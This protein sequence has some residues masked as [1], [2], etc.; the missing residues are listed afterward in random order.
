MQLHYIQPE[1]LP[2]YAQALVHI[3][4]RF[5]LRVVIAFLKRIAALLSY[6]VYI[7]LPTEV[8]QHQN[9]SEQL[10]A[11]RIVR[12]L[13]KAGY[14]QHSRYTTT[15]QP[16]EPPAHILIHKLAEDYGIGWS[17]KAAHTSDKGY[18]Q[19]PALGE[20]VERYSLQHSHF[21]PADLVQSSN[22]NLT[23]PKVDIFAI[24]S[25]S[26]SE[27]QLS[28]AP[29]QLEYTENDVFTWVSVVEAQTGKKVYAPWQWFSFEHL[30]CEV[31]TKK[32]EPLLTPAITTGA[33]A[34]QT[35]EQA[36]LAGLLEVIERDAF[37][38][39]WLQ[40]LQANRMNLT[41]IDNDEVQQLVQLA[42]DYRLELHM[43]YLQTDVPVHTISLVI[44][45][46]SG[47]GPAVNIS[48][49]T[50]FAMIPMIIDVLQD[51]LAQ[52]GIQYDMLKAYPDMA[53]VP[54]SK[55]THVSRMM[56]W[57]N[58]EL[59]PDIEHFLAG[60]LSELTDLPTYQVENTAAARL[61]Y[62]Y[63]WFAEQ[64]YPIYYRE[65]I[66]PELK[67]LTEGVSVVMVKVPAMQP[68][69]LE[70]Q[71]KATGGTRLQS[72]PKVLGLATWHDAHGEYYQVPHPFP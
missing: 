46:R 59:I 19:W 48:A 71:L 22:K 20:A 47:I 12:K 24:A 36:T 15:Q 38:I 28:T 18:L 34:G 6:P 42:K 32:S 63:T 58:S 17:G 23:K 65:I 66:S 60:S 70:E 56:Y 67:E 55:L 21:T 40:Q 8:V 4:Q 51:Q 50:G 30:R 69:Y 1:E 2:E 43:L 33:A 39:Y 41:T 61:A 11:L 62:L 35:L 64:K 27:R 53:D 54:G 29:Y 7:G 49:K 68:L 26:V 13:Q 31:R 25:F 44:L 45:D 57:Q 37:M 72:V 14:I 9:Q 3:E 5:V 16:D 10:R 52:R